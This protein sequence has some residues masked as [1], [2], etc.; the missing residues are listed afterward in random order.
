MVK[1]TIGT[2]KEIFSEKEGFIWKIN[3]LAGHLFLKN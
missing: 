3:Y 2:V 1:N